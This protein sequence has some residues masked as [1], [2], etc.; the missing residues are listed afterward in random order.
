MQQLLLIKQ[1]TEKKTHFFPINKTIQSKIF[2]LFWIIPDTPATAACSGQ[3]WL[4]ADLHCCLQSLQY[5][6]R[7]SDHNAY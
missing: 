1:L 2:I 7:V 6:A 5:W 3:L 4:R